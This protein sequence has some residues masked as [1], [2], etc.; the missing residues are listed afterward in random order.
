MVTKHRLTMSVAAAALAIA[1]QAAA[2]QASPEVGLRAGSFIVTP[3]VTLEGRY[4]DNYLALTSNEVDSFVYSIAP[5]LSFRSDWNRHALAVTFGGKA[6]FVE[7]N[8]NDDMLTYGVDAVGVIDVTRAAAIKL[9]AGYHANE[10]SRGADD[11]P[12]L[13]KEVTEY[14]QV[15]LGIEGRYKA[16]MVRVSPFASYSLYDYDDVSNIGGGS[17]NNDD[18]DR[19]EFGYG[20]E[21]GYEFMRGYEAYV[22]GEA[23]NIEYDDSVDDNGFERDSFGYRGTAGVNFA[24]TRLI[25]GRVGVGYGARDY[26]DARFGSQEAVAVDVGL[27]W[28]VTE[29]TTVD[30]EGFQRFNETT[31][32]ASAGTSE[33]GGKVSV[34]HSLRENIN[35]SGYAGYSNEE[36]EGVAREDDRYEAGVKVGYLIN[37]NFELGAGYD[38]TYEDQ[39]SVGN[40]TENEVYIGLTARY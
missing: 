18:R 31:T 30:I 2:Q 29:L 16:G 17:S 24:V 38:F 19:Q 37:Q 35:L 6:T 28:S 22:R 12:G 20:L 32:A 11:T 4:A 1:G 39:K 13:A 27:E 23:S 14:D 34:L 33:I 15:D 40:V 5:S 36:F 10:E 26:D 3:E 21:I 8:S 9:S 25:E 7:A